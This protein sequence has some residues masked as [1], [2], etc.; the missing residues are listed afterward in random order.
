MANYFS[1]LDEPK[2]ETKTSNSKYFSD[3]PESSSKLNALGFTEGGKKR[4]REAG[5]YGTSLLDRVL[6]P[7]ALQA[8]VLSSKG[9]QHAEFR[10]GIFEDIE[11]LAEQKA[12]GVWD[13]QDEQLFQELQEE[14]KHPEKAE[15]HVKTANLQP[16]HL[17]RKGIK[18]VTGVDLEPQSGSEKVAD[19]LG[20]FKPKEIVNIG[21]AGVDAFSKLKAVPQKLAS[22]L[23]KSRAAES[24]L[25]SIATIGKK[26]QEKAITKLNKEAG[27]LVKKS[28]HEN[29]PL[30]KKVEQGFDSSSLNKSFAHLDK[31]AY[32]S[33]AYVNM[34]PVEKLF[35]TYAEKYNRIP[36]LHPDAKKIVSEI[37]AFTKKPPSNVAAAYKTFRSNNKKLNAIN[38]TAFVTGKQAEYAKFLR[39]ENKAIAQSFRDTLGKDSPFVQYFDMLNNQYAK[40]RTAENT[41]KLFEPM[42]RGENLT[43]KTLSKIAFDP[44]RQKQLLAIT[45]DEQLVKDVVAISKDLLTAKEAI[46]GIPKSNYHKFELAFP[47]T[48]L[49]PGLNVLAKSIGVPYEA[50]KATRHVIGY[51][52]SKPQTRRAYK[53]ALTALINNDIEGYKAATAILRSALESKEE[54]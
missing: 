50:I 17:A 25:T 49:I 24:K 37:K 52:L 26:T 44:K 40:L 20:A 34:D 3:M 28:I 4:A 48:F 54:D 12:T 51:W 19:F 46:K 42:L 8:D 38:E 9:A 7:A 29:V 32:R 13:Q 30:A 53:E 2:S 15:K 14:I 45:K 6:F 27:D 18:A 5:V 23:T 36:S 35:D 33:K 47:I 21:K 43:P 16:S 22:G 10:K 41:L 31:A 1:D 39:E 11:R